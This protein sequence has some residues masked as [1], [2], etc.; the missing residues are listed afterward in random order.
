MCSGRVESDFFQKLTSVNKILIQGWNEEKE[1]KQKKNSKL[2]LDKERIEDRSEFRRL[3]ACT[4]IIS[5]YYKECYGLRRIS[6]KLLCSVKPHIFSVSCAL[7][8]WIWVESQRYFQ[9]LS[10]MSIDPSVLQLFGKINGK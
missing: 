7:D 4:S 1:A 9:L 3:A 10:P 5:P 8:F 6:E 2:H